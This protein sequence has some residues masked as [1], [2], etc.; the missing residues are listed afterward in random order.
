MA[1]ADFTVTLDGVSLSTQ[2]QKQLNS[3]IQQAA[4]SALAG[5]GIRNTIGVHLPFNGTRGIVV[6]SLR[7]P[8]KARLAKLRR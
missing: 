5:F 8:E 7:G 6:M 3:A 2:Q 4:L 1:R